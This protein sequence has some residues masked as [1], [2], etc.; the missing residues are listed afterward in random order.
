MNITELAKTLVFEQKLNP[1]GFLGY[2]VFVKT[3]SLVWY[4]ISS[5][6][7]IFSKKVEQ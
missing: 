5:L 4:I 1:T 2:L 3:K 6:V 7:Q